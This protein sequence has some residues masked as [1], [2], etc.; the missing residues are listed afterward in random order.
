MF[1]PERVSGWSP[2]GQLANPREELFENVR[3]LKE[4]S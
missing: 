4:G 3:N 2:R 1:H